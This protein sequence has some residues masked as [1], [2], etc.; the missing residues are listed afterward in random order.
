MKSGEICEEKMALI[1]EALQII[2]ELGDHNF[3]DHEDFLH[4]EHKLFELVR[5]ARILRINKYFKT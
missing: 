4:D 3:E 5:R 2:Y 1:K